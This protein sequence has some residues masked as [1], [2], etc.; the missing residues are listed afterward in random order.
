MESIELVSR[1]KNIFYTMADLHCPVRTWQL[2]FLEPMVSQLHGS[3]PYK[4]TIST[5]QK[6]NQVCAHYLEKL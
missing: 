2:A 4:E 3:Q 1:E 6:L 5:E